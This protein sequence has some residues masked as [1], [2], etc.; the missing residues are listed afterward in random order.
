M[1]N[2]EVNE[3][4]R[5]KPK[6]KTIPPP[7]SSENARRAQPL[8]VASRRAN[9]QTLRDA[10]ADLLPAMPARLRQEVADLLPI[11]E[12]ERLRLAALEY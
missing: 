3:N 1:F 7:F 5:P 12:V 6:S 4:M 8:A 10:V 2:G 9:D 11:R